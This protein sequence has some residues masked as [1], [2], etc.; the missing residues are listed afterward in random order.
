MSI[1]IFICKTKMVYLWFI[2]AENLLD[3]IVFK[4]QFTYQKCC[5]IQHW[6]YVVFLLAW[7]ILKVRENLNL[8]LNYIYIYLIALSTVNN[9][10]C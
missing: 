5:F 2:S 6:I 8:T 3:Q 10:K 7:P 4:G 1:Y 9:E